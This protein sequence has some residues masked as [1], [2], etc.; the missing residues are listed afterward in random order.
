MSAHSTRCRHRWRSQLPL[1]SLHSKSVH[2]EAKD[3]LHL[4]QALCPTFGNHRIYQLQHAENESALNAV[5][6][7]SAETECLPKVP[8]CPHSVPNPKPKPKFGR[9]LTLSHACV[10]VPKEIWIVTY[11]NCRTS[12]SPEAFIMV[13]IIAVM[14]VIKITSLM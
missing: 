3:C 10:L 9:P 5:R 8:I 7:L 14:C 12:C 6:L 13:M 4:A 11:K 1:L 2:S